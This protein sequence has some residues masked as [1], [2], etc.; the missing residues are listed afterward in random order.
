MDRWNG[1]I[2]LVTG[3]SSGIGAA[4]AK[5]FVAHGMKVVGCARN[6][7]ALKKIAEEV[8]KRGPGELWPIKCDLQVEA[9]ILKLFQEIDA[10]YGGLHVLIN[11]A[12]L[13]HDAPLLSGNTEDWKSMMSINVM[14]VCICCREAVKL[15]D[16]AG[17]DDGHIVNMNS[18]SGHAVDDRPDAHFYQITKYAVTAMTEGLRRELVS[19]KS[20]IRVTSISPGLVGTDFQR[21]WFPDDPE[22]VAKIHSQYV[23][24]TADDIADDVVFVLST[25]AR[26]NICEVL[27]RPTEQLR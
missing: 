9:D 26:V 21:R 22:R 16:K 13:A 12:G 25:P 20:H 6:I 15:M 17:V 19:R 4:I 2:A 1:K 7:E 18:T 14:A 3:A 11:N 10:K 8:N 23:E 5:K 24:L 27:V